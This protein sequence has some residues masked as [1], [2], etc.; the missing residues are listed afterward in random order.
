M[1]TA[2]RLLLLVLCL[3]SPALADDPSLEDALLDRLAGEWVLRGTI[4]GQETTHDIVAEWVLQ[5]QYL[6]FYEL[7][8]ERDERGLPAYE[9]TV[10]I[11]WDEAS[12]RYV[13]LWLDSTGGYGLNPE[14][15]GYAEPSDD[16]LAF[17]FGTPEEGMLHTT[18]AYDHERDAWRWTIDS[19]KASVRKPFASVELTRR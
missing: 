14:A 1:K 17:K 13:C 5:H 9:A 8:R 16:T 15:F 19:E 11:G 6:S 7:A 4:A 3:G 12:N 2:L 18:F 10:F